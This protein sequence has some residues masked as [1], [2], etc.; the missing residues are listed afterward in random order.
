MFKK[1]LVV[2][3]G[4]IAW[5]GPFCS[6]CQTEANQIMTRIGRSR[7]SGNRKIIGPMD[8]SKGASK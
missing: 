2:G 1:C 3:C 8:F 6:K 4:R 5:T 7:N